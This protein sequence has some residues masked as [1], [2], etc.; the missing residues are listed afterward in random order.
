VAVLLVAASCAAA[1]S[2]SRADVDPKGL[3]VRAQDLPRSFH[4]KEKHDYVIT[5]AQLGE[6]GFVIGHST[7][8][9]EGPQGIAVF[10][11]GYGVRTAAQAAVFPRFYRGNC[12][13]GAVLT[14]IEIGIAADLCSYTATDVPSFTV[15]WQRDGVAG[16]VLVFGQPAKR[17]LAVALALARG[18]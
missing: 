16:R 4:L 9:D 15:S 18:Q 17:S 11:D 3:A 7:S 8:Y 13:H 1:A 12:K 2:A 14:R 6:P 10:S 5:P